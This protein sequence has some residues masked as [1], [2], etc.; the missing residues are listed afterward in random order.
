VAP[1]GCRQNQQDFAPAAWWPTR[2]AHSSKR[3]PL[4]GAGPASRYSTAFAPTACWPPGSKRSP[5][6]HAGPP[7]NQRSPLLHAGPPS[8]KRSSLLRGGQPGNKH[9][10]CP[11][12]GPPGGNRSPLLSNCMLA[13]FH[14]RVSPRRLYLTHF[15]FGRDCMKATLQPTFVIHKHLLMFPGW[16]LPARLSTLVLSC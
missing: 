5:L 16:T 1:D 4:L 15:R 6:L 7:T 10:T 14:S 12:A 13:I 8:S 2:L 9:S 11:G 3:S